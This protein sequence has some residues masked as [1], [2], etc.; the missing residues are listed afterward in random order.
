MSLGH[1]QP[2]LRRWASAH[3]P[4][5]PLLSPALRLQLLVALSTQH[6][7]WLPGPLGDPQRRCVCWQVMQR[8]FPDMF[9]AQPD[10]LFQLVTMLNPAVLRKHGVPV[11]TTLQ[12]SPQCTLPRSSLRNCCNRAYGSVSNMRSSFLRV[13][14]SRLNFSL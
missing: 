11:Y 12:V 5:Q 13:P 9:A 8:S 4:L 3:T 6:A 7:C 2:S 1:M 10:L 14:M